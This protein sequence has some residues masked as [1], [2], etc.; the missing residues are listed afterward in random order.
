MTDDPWDRAARAMLAPTRELEPTDD[1]LRRVLALHDRRTARR[2]SRAR[3]LAAGASAAMLLGAGSYAVPATRAA[4]NDVYGWIAPWF[5]DDGQAPGRALTAQDD[6][7]DWVRQ[8]PGEKRVIAE[9]GGVKL[10]AVRGSGDRLSVALGDSFGESGSID[11]WRERFADHAIVVL[12]PAS[13]SPTRQF[14]EHWRRP[15]FGLVSKPV[16]RIELDYASGPP[17]TQDGLRGGFGLLADA[18]R[19]LRALI[20]YD[21]AGRQIGRLDMSGLDLRICKEVRGCPPGRLIPDRAP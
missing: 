5:G 17:A 20:G 18:M 4:V 6:A 16:T 8:E 9:A 10:I 13:F 14:D 12:G 2:R 19:P 3:R 15:L 21:A 1:E 7:P 11:S